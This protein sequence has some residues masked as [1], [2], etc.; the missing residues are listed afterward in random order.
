LTIEEKEECGYKRE[1][2]DT[3]KIE[4]GATVMISKAI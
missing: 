4:Q 2:K 3:K 1:V